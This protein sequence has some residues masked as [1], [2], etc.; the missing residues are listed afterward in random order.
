MCPPASPLPLG[1]I[2]RW[3]AKPQR[4]SQKGGALFQWIV[5]CWRLEV[6]GSKAFPHVFGCRQWRS[7]CYQLIFL[8]I[9]PLSLDTAW[10]EAYAVHFEMSLLG[11]CEWPCFRSRGADPRAKRACGMI[12]FSWDTPMLDV[13]LKG[14]RADFFSGPKTNISANKTSQ[15][16]ALWVGEGAVLSWFPPNSLLSWLLVAKAFVHSEVSLC[17]RCFEPCF[18]DKEHVI[19]EWKEKP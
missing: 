12:D 8:G 7:P 17:F 18:Y 10:W 15:F 4:E 3:P 9:L 19:S 2:H 11:I 13:V 6:Y 1:Q 14:C 16:Y 5:G